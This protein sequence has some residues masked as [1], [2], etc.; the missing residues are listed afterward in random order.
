MLKQR[1][2]F[3]QKGVSWGPQV[4]FT[5]E[6]A[7]AGAFCC[8]KKDAC[9]WK[10]LFLGPQALLT[11]EQLAAGAFCFWRVACIFATKRLGEYLSML[12]FGT[13]YLIFVN[14]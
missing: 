4:M 8:L 3:F 2:A 5:A 6:Q 13:C 1:H 11:A 12:Q 9:F 7:A 14:I 10:G